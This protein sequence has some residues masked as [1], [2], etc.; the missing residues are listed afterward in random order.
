MQVSYSIV[1]A[2]VQNVVILGGR[3]SGQLIL[4]SLFTDKL[5]LHC[6]A[7]LYSSAFL[8]NK[9]TSEILIPCAALGIY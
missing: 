7:V 9:I 8:H 4:M 6:S 5:P 1:T 2:D 3:K